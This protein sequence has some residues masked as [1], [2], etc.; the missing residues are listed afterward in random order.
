[1]NVFCYLNRS[2]GWIVIQR[3]IDNTVDFRRGWQDYKNGFGDSSGNMWMGLDKIHHLAGPGR[4]AILRFDL[5]HLYNPTRVYY[6]EYTTFEV[7]SEADK[8]K[9][10]IGGYSGDAGDSMAYHNGM[11]FTTKDNDNDVHRGN[12]AIIWSGAWWHK[13]CHWVNLNGLFPTVQS[14]SPHYMSWLGIYGSHGNIFFSEM[15]IKY[16]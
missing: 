12:C 1:M 6:A 10:L 5:K 4:R 11:K 3:R 16:G 13:I 8:Y 9:L 15:K 2:T 7:G 14:T